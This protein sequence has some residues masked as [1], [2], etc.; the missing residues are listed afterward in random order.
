MPLNIADAAPL[1]WIWYGSPTTIESDE[2]TID[3]ED[4]GNSGYQY[5]SLTNTW[6]FNWKT[7]GLTAGI[8]TICIKC[9]STGQ[10]DGPFPIQLR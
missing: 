2:G 1:V 8:Y 9:G 3:L 7:K 5:D 6:Q 4:A 10:I